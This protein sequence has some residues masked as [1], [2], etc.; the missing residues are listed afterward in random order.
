MP[1][2]HCFCSPCI[3]WWAENKPKF[4][5]CKRGMQS[6]LHSVRADTDYQEHVLTPSVPTS[7]FVSDTQLAPTVPDDDGLQGRGSTQWWAANEVPKHSVNILQHPNWLNAFQ[8]H[9]ISSRPCSPRSI[10]RCRR[11]L[12][13]ACY[14]QLWWR[15]HSRAFMGWIRSCWSGCWGSPSRTPVAPALLPPKEGLPAPA[16]PPVPALP[17]PA[18]MSSP[19]PHPLPLLRVPAA[20]ALL[21]LPP[22]WSKK[23]PR[24]SQGRLCLAC[25]L[26]ARAGITPLGG[27]DDPQRGGLAGLRALQPPRGQH[28]ISDAGGCLGGWPQQDW[29]HPLVPAPAFKGSQPPPD[30]IILTK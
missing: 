16:Q 18:G 8:T 30:P 29:A 1:C 20:T 12:A 10:R 9:L 15:T 6:T 14:R 11:P 25:P 17:H 26:P 22:P 24:R 21:L 7:D 23:N 27:Y 28:H 3:L 19:P 2:L 13:T 5:L 4:P